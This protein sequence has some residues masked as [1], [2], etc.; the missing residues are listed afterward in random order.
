MIKTLKYITYICKRAS[1]IVYFSHISGITLLGV[2][3]EIYSNGTQYLI[4]GVVNNIVVI[5][6]VIYIY[7]PVFYDLQLTSV[8]EV[9]VF[10]YK[11][12]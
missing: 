6:M 3:S 1:I 7:L 5:F 8:Y 2:P 4:V 12:S 10:C 11:W 9:N